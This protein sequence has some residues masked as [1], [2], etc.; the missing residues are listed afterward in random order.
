MAGKESLI[1]AIHTVIIKKMK[2]TYQIFKLI[3]RKM[4]IKS[5]QTFLHKTKQIRIEFHRIKMQISIKKMVSIIL[6]AL[7]SLNSNINSKLIISIIS[8][9]IKKLKT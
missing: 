8:Q 4:K 6:M 7:T 1:K 9:Q 2:S 5:N 3:Y